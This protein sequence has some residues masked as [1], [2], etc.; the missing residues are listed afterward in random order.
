MQEYD[1]TL[2]YRL[3]NPQQ[4][5][6]QYVESLAQSGCEDAVIGVGQQGHISLNFMRTAS[7]EQNAVAS[8]RA[9]VARILP[10]ASLLTALLKTGIC[11]PHIAWIASGHGG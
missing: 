9:D 10:N 3:S 1:F 4:D 7:S 6:A 8:A 11:R 2:R 5:A